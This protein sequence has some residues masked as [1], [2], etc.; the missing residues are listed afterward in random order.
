MGE[1]H[2]KGQRPS[3]VVTGKKKKKEH[4][5]KLKFFNNVKRGKMIL[6]IL[7]GARQ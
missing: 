3:V 7:S 1:S 2:K 4:N 5:M 6:L